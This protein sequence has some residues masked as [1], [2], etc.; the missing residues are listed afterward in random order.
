MRVPSAPHAAI[1][2]AQAVAAKA[3]AGQNIGGTL[4]GT[5]QG[6]MPPVPGNGP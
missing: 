1:V 4:S 2:K 5:P 3:Q 6:G